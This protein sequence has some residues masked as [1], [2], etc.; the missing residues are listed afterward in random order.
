[1]TEKQEVSEMSLLDRRACKGNACFAPFTTHARW[2]I[3]A[4]TF[5]VARHMFTNVQ[6]QDVSTSEAFS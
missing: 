4:A 5:A 2:H 6:H 3:M 1:M